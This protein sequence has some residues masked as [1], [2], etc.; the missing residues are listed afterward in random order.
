MLSE[1]NCAISMYFM[2]T[3]NNISFIDIFYF[4]GIPY[5]KKR[6]YN[7]SQWINFLVE[8]HLKKVIFEMMS[9]I[10]NFT[11]VPAIHI[12]HIHL[13]LFCLQNTL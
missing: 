11:V 4:K 1:Y 13:N 9:L 8:S 3:S 2:I 6:R 5:L 10:Y 12:Y 7:R